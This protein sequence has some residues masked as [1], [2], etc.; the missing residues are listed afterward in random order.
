MGPG[1]A[2]LL[3]ARDADPGGRSSSAWPQFTVA[4]STLIKYAFTEAFRRHALE[5]KTPNPS[6]KRYES[7][8]L[9]VYG[10]IQTL[11]SAVAPNTKNADGGMGGTNKT[12]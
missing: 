9:K 3:Q 4:K 6:K 5:P 10:D 8:Q 11:T 7:P 1:I 2:C 12:G